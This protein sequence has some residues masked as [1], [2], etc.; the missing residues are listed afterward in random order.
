LPDQLQASMP[1]A[2]LALP[3]GDS[4]PLNSHLPTPQ[5]DSTRSVYPI[6]IFGPQYFI[7]YSMV[8]ISKSLFDDR[9]AF[10]AGADGES[11]TAE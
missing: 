10:F 11:S 3:R 6:Q 5:P 1:S 8:T 9:S 4:H 2:E 7:K